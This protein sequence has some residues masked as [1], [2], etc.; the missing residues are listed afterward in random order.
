MSGECSRMLNKMLVRIVNR[1][2]SDQRQSDL[3]LHC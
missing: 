1:E 3:G 2:D